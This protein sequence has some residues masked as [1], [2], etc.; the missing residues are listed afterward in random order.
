MITKKKFIVIC[1]KDLEW[2]IFLPL[3]IIVSLLLSNCG[4]YLDNYKT[5]EVFSFNNDDVFIREDLP[6]SIQMIY[7]PLYNLKFLPEPDFSNYVIKLASQI[8]H[9]QEEEVGNE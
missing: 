8:S 3:V 9:K 4:F 7:Y 6:L 1:K 2:I 5:I